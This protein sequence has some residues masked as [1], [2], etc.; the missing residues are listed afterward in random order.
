MAL[1]KGPDV[2]KAAIYLKVENFHIYVN[3]RAAGDLAYC[4]KPEFEVLWCGG[5]L[6]EIY[7]CP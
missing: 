1:D 2:E 5:T 4:H 3:Q 6:E 7:C